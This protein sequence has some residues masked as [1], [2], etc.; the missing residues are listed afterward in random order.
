M[1]PKSFTNFIPVT[2]TDTKEEEELEALEKELDI[3]SVKK[4]D[5]LERQDRLNLKQHK[6]GK[7]VYYNLSYMMEMNLSVAFVHQEVHLSEN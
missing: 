3:L 2:L 1:K 5:L 4:K 7:T 6:T